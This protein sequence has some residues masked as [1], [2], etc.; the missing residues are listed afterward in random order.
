[1][2]SV[3]L[4][5]IGANIARSQSPRLHVEA[6]RLCGVEVR[7]ER[8]V[9]RDLGLDFGAVF[10]RCLDE[11]FRGV[12]VTYP[13]KEEVVARVKLSDPPTARIGACNTVLFGNGGP[14]GHN[15]DHSGFISAFEASFGKTAPGKVALVGAGGVGK[16]IA[17]AL[18][19]LGAGELRIFDTDPGK[20]HRL[21]AMLSEAG[22]APRVIRATST[23]EAVEHADGLVN[24]T[25]IG[26]SGHSGSSMERRH[27]VGAS[28]AFDAV[29]TPVDTDFL[30]SAAD[31]GLAIM[32]GW[33]LFFYQGLDAFRHFTGAEVDPLS[34]RRVLRA[35]DEKKLHA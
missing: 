5:L 27:M 10:D 15:T 18:V 14:L 22:A 4:G 30:R 28:W 7:Y 16:A 1:M 19:R 12:N 32:T 9:P 31:A 2:G 25:P 3:R 6:G 17:F 26:M 21:A 20:A 34:L 8:L 35:N 33:E 29:Y 13:Y 11:G 24:C 23:E